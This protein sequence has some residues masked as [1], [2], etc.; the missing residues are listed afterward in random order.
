MDKINTLPVLDEMVPKQIVEQ[1]DKYIIGKKGRPT[2]Y[3]ELGEATIAKT[4]KP[5]ANALSCNMQITSKNS[6][7]HIIASGK[8]IHKLTNG[9]Y[10][11]D[12]HYV[13][14][15]NDAEIIKIDDE[16]TQLLSHVP[17]GKHEINY[18]IAW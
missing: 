2:F 4:Y 1:F 16:V 8:E 15:K 13:F 12:D 10:K 17:A 14:L 3:F 6:T 11:V 18:K 7:D 9:V 5:D